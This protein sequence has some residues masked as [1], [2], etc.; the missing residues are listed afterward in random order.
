M[1]NSIDSVLKKAAIASAV[2][3]ALGGSAQAAFTPLPAST[4]FR[5][6]ITGGCFDFGD[7]TVSGNGVFVD[8]A[9]TETSIDVTF[10]SGAI[11]P[12]TYGSGIAGDGVMGFID[13]VT[14]PTGT[15]FSVTSF[16]QDSYLATSGG[17][18]FLDAGLAGNEGL[19]SGTISAT[20]DLT[21][22]PTGRYGMAGNFLTSLGSQ[23]WNRDNTTNNLGS[24][25]YNTLT[26]GASTNRRQGAADPFT[27]TGSVLSD[28]GAGAW[29][30]AMV[31]A[32]NVG[33]SW[34]GFNNTQYAELWNIEIA[35]LQTPV[36]VEDTAN[37]PPGNAVTINVLA[38]DN[39]PQGGA[40]TIDSVDTS[41][42]EPGSTAVINAGQIIYTPA[43]G[44]SGNDVFTY[45]VSSPAG[46][47]ANSATVTVSVTAAGNTAP[48]ANDDALTTDEDVAGTTVDVTLN[49]TDVDGD[50]L[51]V[52]SNT[53]A[54]KGTVVDNGDNTFTYTPNINFSGTDSFTYTVADGNG[55]ISN[56]ARV[57]I[58]I[59]AL[60]DPPVASDD[61]AS[62]T[63]DT[64]VDI[65]VLAND[66][67]PDT[68]DVLSV[69]SFTQAGNGVVT[70]KSN[71]ILNYAPNAGFG[72]RDQFT[73]VVSDGNGGTDTATVTIDV[74][75]VSFAGPVAP[76]NLV[77]E[78]PQV[79]PDI[80][81]GSNFTMLNASGSDIG[82][83]ND[84]G[85]TW[86]G[87]IYTS[88]SQTA[89]S[90]RIFTAGTGPDAGK[91]T[92]FFGF[93]WQAT[94]IRVFGPGDY[95]FVTCPPGTL[96]DSGT[97]LGWISDT[98]L[99][100]D[101]STNCNEPPAVNELTMTVGPKQLGAH[102]LFNWNLS[103]NIDVVMVWDINQAWTGPGVGSGTKAVTGAVFNLSVIDDDGGDGFNG[104]PM[105]DGPFGGFSANFN[106]NLDPL[107]SLP[108]AIVSAAQAGGTTSV[109]VPG[110]GNVTVTATTDSGNVDY[111]WSASDPA[112][113]AAAVGGI[114]N[115]TLVFDP[116]GLAN[117]VAVARVTITDNDKGGLQNDTELALAIDSAQTLANAA[118]DDGNGIPNAQD[119]GDPTRLQ[120]EAGN[121][122]T[123][124]LQTSAGQ[125][126]LGSMA[127]ANGAGG[128]GYAAGVT[129]TEIGLVDAA[130]TD[131]CVGG[132]YD[133]EVVGITQGGSVSVVLPQINPLPAD[134]VYRSYVNGQWRNFRAT[135]TT[136][137]SPQGGSI[138]SAP[139]GPGTCPAP[140]DSAYAPGLNEGDFCV[141]LTLND[142][143][144]N[145][146]DGTANGRIVDPSGVGGGVVVQAEQISSIG[147]PDTGG[148]T[149]AQNSV[150]PLKHSD[151]WLLMSAILGL[152][153]WTRFSKGA[154]KKAE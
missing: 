142:G 53:D 140:N 92:P 56:P 96:R 7:C 55:G 124:L 80:S 29:T 17:T 69:Q 62:T 26:T 48:V 129:T 119:L 103:K 28:T 64:P 137:G 151:W 58:T 152:F 85:V 125:L 1:M 38:N 12:G 63:P 146:A 19:M 39:D 25:L 149:V 78:I 107:F 73:Y 40:L 127:S 30:G 122:T 150:N 4:S 117:G 50:T 74:V 93:V 66:I 98:G 68:D 84:I 57:D 133:F 108:V 88:E 45:K 16:A 71:G 9:T 81:G 110:Q 89:T 94:T 5:V 2:S 32:G 113:V 128:N 136:E 3:L 135:G 121:N 147:S 79:S 65:N 82:G 46:A 24:G 10:S 27:L 130:V 111:D 112:L 99:G 22:D 15:G 143:G 116:T 144:L 77:F 148:C 21:L 20:G 154:R 61:A 59:N 52:D 104:H 109:V 87:N 114:T 35:Q 37:T 43:G 51:T 134:A 47:S 86:D 34:G 23:E 97:A 72:G 8:N 139:G 90:M 141:Q 132:C 123:Y 70:D 36:A 95:T 100:G 41:K 105:A 44:F 106:L 67:D 13:I 6:T 115:A 11:T 153:G 33:S 91:G 120:G 126:K 14:D 54:T 102:M 76:D 42:L 131:S 138:A 118:D 60:N 75:A 18:F 83:T 145:D 31:S 49:D 101:G